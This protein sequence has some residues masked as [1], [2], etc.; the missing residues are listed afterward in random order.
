MDL[1]RSGT[2]SIPL[3]KDEKDEFLRR[4]NELQDQIAEKESQLAKA[5]DHL[6]TVKDEL[7]YYKERDAKSLKDNERVNGELNELK[8]QVEKLN[9][10]GKEALITMDS[11]KEANLELTSELDDVK[12]QLLDAKMNAKLEHLRWIPSCLD[13][14]IHLVVGVL[15]NRSLP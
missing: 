2:P 11:L 10:E 3:E 1:E 15:W 6:K 14:V 5:E 7:Q 4:E 12:Q 9:F 8:M 13:A